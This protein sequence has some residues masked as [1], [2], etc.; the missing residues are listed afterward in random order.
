M[1]LFHDH[2]Y[3]YDCSNMIDQ[4]QNY[5]CSKMDVILFVISFFNFSF[6]SGLT[7]AN[8]IVKHFGIIVVQN[9]IRSSTG[10]PENILLII[11]SIISCISGR[12]K[13]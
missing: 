12:V 10:I 5:S 11:V 4:Q 6:A 13:V 1:V 3:I 9:W 2:Y 8:T 7:P